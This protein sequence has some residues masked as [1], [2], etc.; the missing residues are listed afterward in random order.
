MDVHCHGLACSKVHDAL[1]RTGVVGVRTDRTEGTGWCW[2]GRHGVHHDTAICVNQGVVVHIAVSTVDID[3][4]VSSITVTVDGVS[5]E[6]EVLS[7]VHVDSIR[8]C[9]DGVVR[10]DSPFVTTWVERNCTVAGI[11][12]VEGVTCDDCRVCVT[13]C[14]EPNICD[15]AT[16]VERV[17]RDGDV[18]GSKHTVVV[19][20][21]GCTLEHD[22]DTTVVEGV[23]R[24]DAAVATRNLH[25]DV[26]DLDSVIQRGVTLVVCNGRVGDR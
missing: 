20:V 15:F 26:C 25:A 3:T 5:S 18:I 23:T 14:V 4:C 17:V 6:G 2:W 16:I 1:H 24:D 13:A 8:Q 21:V 12:A 11:T 9:V 22:T 19:A 7:T 10:N